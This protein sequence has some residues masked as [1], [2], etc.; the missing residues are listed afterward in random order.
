MDLYW[1]ALG[2][3]LVAIILAL[4]LEKQGKDFSLLITVSVSVMIAAI[5]AGFLSPVT[6]FLGR[7]E[8]LGDLNEAMLA[9]LLKVLGIGLTGEIASSVCTDAGNSSVAKC[10]RFLANAAITYL[11][12]PIYTSLIDLIQQIMGSV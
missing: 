3:A 5:A 8:T 9:E 1:K 4:A 12:L 10:I 2:G 7:L 11:S 6:D